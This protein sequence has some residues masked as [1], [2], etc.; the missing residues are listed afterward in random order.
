[1]QLVERWFDNTIG[2]VLKDHED[3]EPQRMLLKRLHGDPVERF[4]ITPNFDNF[5]ILAG[6]PSDA[7]LLMFI[8]AVKISNHNSLKNIPSEDLFTIVLL[9]RM[10]QENAIKFFEAKLILRTIHDCKNGKIPA[11]FDFPETLS[12][13]ALRVSFMYTKLFIVLQSCLSSAGLKGYQVMCQLCL[14]LIC[15]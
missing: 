10:V 15:Y 2:I 3:V 6:E 14:Y 5:C 4:E 13:R 12:A 1:M 9:T 11:D 7:E 8:A